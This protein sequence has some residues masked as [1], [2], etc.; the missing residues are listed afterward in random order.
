MSLTTPVATPLTPPSEVEKEIESRVRKAFAG[1]GYVT[2]TGEPDARAMQ[3]AAYKAVRDRI[4]TSKTERAEKGISK[5]Q[6]CAAVFPN[7]PGAVRKFDELDEF[8]QKA[9]EKLEREVWGLT[10][11]KSTGAI[12]KRLEDEG[13]G[14]TLLRPTIRRELDP[15]QV[16][17]L[18]EN[19]TLIKEDGLDKEIKAWERKAANLRKELDMFLRRHPE[20]E[21]H[22]RSE[23][24]QGL[25]RAK[26]TLAFSANGQKELSKGDDK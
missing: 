19:T 17:Y 7:A 12:Q 5:G 3:D 10:Q 26:A 13:T 22:I 1:E 14:Q 24:G 23:V 21:A 11:P 25:N 20:L 2:E 15:V 18:T 8:D 6:L 4:V 9:W 16:V